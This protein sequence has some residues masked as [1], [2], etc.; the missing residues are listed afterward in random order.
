MMTDLLVC[1]SFGRFVKQA[2]DRL[3]VHLTMDFLE[4][5]V[6]LLQS[7]QDRDLD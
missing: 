3:Q 7:M 5:I 6:T 4:D 1:T 2:L